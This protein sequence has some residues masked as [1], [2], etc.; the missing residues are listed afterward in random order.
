M[1]AQE[2][3]V[4]EA[5]EVVVTTSKPEPVN[6]RK[7]QPRYAVV[8]LND[9]IHTFHYV[10]L[11][12]GRVF[13]YGIER[14]LELATETRSTARVRPR[15]ICGTSCDISVRRRVRAH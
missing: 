11:A 12:L 7:R 1:N 8:V 6:Q 14:G 9:D 10:I 15:S 13:G 2:T 4:D 5:V 3:A